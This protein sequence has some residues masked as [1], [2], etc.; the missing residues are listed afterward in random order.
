MPPEMMKI[1]QSVQ[2]FITTAT[3]AGNIA[4]PFHYPVLN[5]LIGYQSGFRYHGITGEDLTSTKEG[6]WQPGWYV[7]VLNGMDDPFFV[8]FT[9]VDLPVYYAP[10]GAGKWVPVM[11]AES[12]SHFA[13]LLNG[14]KDLQQNDA[15]ALRY[16][17]EN[18]DIHN[19]LWA[20]VYAGIQEAPQE[21][22]NT[23]VDPE[24]FIRAS[25]IIT[26]VGENKMKVVQFLKEKLGLDGKEALALSKQP[27][28]TVAEGYVAHLRRTLN[29]LE[30][31]G[32][33]AVLKLHNEN[34]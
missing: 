19:E 25:I 5:E 21:E 7:I 14:L 27:E 15:A 12:I 33:T 4:L 34:I 13:V 17:E 1:P 26:N 8:D 10:H 24:Q 20:E 23:P 22:D 3:V 30:T 18:V 28:I 29:H 32:A 16:L 9:E 2:D 31:L 11:V 6:D